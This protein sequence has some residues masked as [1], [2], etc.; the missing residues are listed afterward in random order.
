MA[1]KSTYLENAI[2]NWLR[3]TAFPAPPAGLFV[4]LFNG[5]PTDAG[6]GGQEVTSAVSSAGRVQATFGAPANKTISNTAV[7]DFGNAEGG[8]DVTHF[9][10]FSQ[11]A[12]GSMLESAPLQGGKQTINPGNPVSFPVG[13]LSITED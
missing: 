12:G 5:D 8:T 11:A 13:A 3:G 4:A 10:V 2:L 1:G 9:A 7:V 6:T